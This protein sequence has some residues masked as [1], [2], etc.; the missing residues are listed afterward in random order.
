MSGSI[1]GATAGN[2]I[3]GMTGRIMSIDVGVYTGNVD[4]GNFL[5]AIDFKVAT[6]GNGYTMEQAAQACQ[7]LLTSRV[8]ADVPYLSRSGMIMKP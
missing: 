4:I 8:S 1:T 6:E 7:V 3:G 5:E 2:G